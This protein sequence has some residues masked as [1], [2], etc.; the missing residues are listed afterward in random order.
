MAVV[1]CRGLCKKHYRAWLKAN[2]PVDPAIVAAHIEALRERG[3]GYRR[4]A[5]LSGAGMT[6]IFEI[7]KG[8]K[9]YIEAPT[10]AAIF[11][12]PFDAQPARMDPIGVVR[13]VR[14]LVALGYTEVQIAEHIS[15][16]QSN[17]WPYTFGRASWVRPETFNRIA[18]VFRV[19]EGQAAPVGPAADR[20]RRRAA[21]RSWLPPLAWDIETIDDPAAEPI[22]EA[23]RRDTPWNGVLDEFRDEYL[24]LRDHLRMSD[25]LIADRLGITMDLILKRLSRLGIATQNAA[26][27]A[28]R[29]AS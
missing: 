3:H 9:K 24:D 27:A 26:T 28:E 2:P 15:I 10:A 21:E 12:V 4:I 16:R 22:V 5:D 19:L 20:A 7:A 18:A 13:R 25:E 1:A 23:I 29:R 14:A 8:K 17:L 11:A 6:T